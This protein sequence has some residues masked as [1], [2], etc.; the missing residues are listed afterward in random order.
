MIPLGRLDPRA[1]HV[2]GGQVVH[3]TPLGTQQI[4]L[5]HETT[6]PGQIAGLVEQFGEQRTRKPRRVRVGPHCR[7][8]LERRSEVL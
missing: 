3:C 6:S 4:A 7:A 2:P 1:D 5:V 8:D